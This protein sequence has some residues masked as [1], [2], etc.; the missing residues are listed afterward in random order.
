MAEFRPGYEHQTTTHEVEKRWNKS[1]RLDRGLSQMG[2]LVISPTNEGQFVPQQLVRE[3]K[4]DFA[5][6]YY[7]E[8]VLDETPEG[9][10]AVILFPSEDAPR[11]GDEDKVFF[12]EMRRLWSRSEQ[13]HLVVLKMEAEGYEEEL[14]S[15]LDLKRNELQEVLSPL[16]DVDLPRLVFLHLNA[17]LKP[18][19]IASFINTVN[20]DTKWAAEDVQI[21]QALLDQVIE[22]HELRSAGRKRDRDQSLQK[23]GLLVIEYIMTHGTEGFSPALQRR[24]KATDLQAMKE[25]YFE[26]K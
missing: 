12:D 26:A 11:S 10:R 17:G 1:F 5:E 3:L 19:D 4:E 22:A 9:V 16:G 21:P 20:G 13:D 6:T 2:K 14:E 25:R 15:E 24:L 8:V 18:E 7:L 23:M